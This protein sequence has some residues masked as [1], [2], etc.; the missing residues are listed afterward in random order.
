MAVRIGVRPEVRARIPSRA[1]GA[2]ATHLDEAGTVPI[3]RH[4]TTMRSDEQQRIACCA[5]TRYYIARHDA[6]GF[7]VCAHASGRDAVDSDEIACLYAREGGRA[8]VCRETHEQ[9]L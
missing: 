2:G 8:L 5:A 1:A 3:Q 4:R 6:D 9:N 7:A